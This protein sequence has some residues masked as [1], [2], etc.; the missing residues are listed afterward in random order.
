VPVW[1]SSQVEAKKDKQA[2]T[3]QRSESGDLP[4]P[5]AETWMRA[6]RGAAAE[7]QQRP[8]RR[9]EKGDVN[10]LLSASQPWSKSS[11]MGDEVPVA[12]ACLPSMTSIVCEVHCVSSLLLPRGTT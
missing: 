2:M 3:M 12:R 10:A 6:L 11:P 1:Y 9:R 5:S 8:V 7:S 4:R